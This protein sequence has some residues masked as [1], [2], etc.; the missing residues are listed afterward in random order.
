MHAGP[1]AMTTLNNYTLWPASDLCLESA[2]LFLDVDGTLLDF[3]QT[4]DSVRVPPQLIDL[5]R[6]LSLR[7][8][9]ALALVSG[10]P[11]AQIDELFAP[12]MVPAAGLHGFERRS[13][14]G[15][16]HRQPLPAGAALEF[17]RRVMRRLAGQHAGLL[18]EDKR[19][20]LALHY[21]RAPHLAQA[22][23]HAMNLVA[24]RV[25]PDL[26]LQ[27]GKMVVELRPAGATKGSA[28]LGFLLEHPFWGRRPLY[29]GDDFTDETAFE[30]VNDMRGLS[31]GVDI[32]WPTSAKAR[33]P[34]PPAV[35]NLLRDLL[36]QPL[37]G[38]PC[39]SGTIAG[40][41]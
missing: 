41:A 38:L 2:A 15:S 23:L 22:V 3:A 33:L 30:C 26:E 8:G 28:V 37:A 25:R 16:Y 12:L 24:A 9:G 36:R 29:I 14:Q 40:R 6:A 31:V 4:P 39:A 19:F 11:I 7:T 21:R 18:V 35:H 10:R 32:S 17:A 1:E 13:G 5:L 34:D 27:L 20:A